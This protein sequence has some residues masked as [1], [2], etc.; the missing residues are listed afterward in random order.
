VNFLENVNINTDKTSSGFYKKPQALGLELFLLMLSGNMKL[1]V[2]GRKYIFYMYLVLFGSCTREMVSLLLEAASSALSDV[3]PMS[4]YAYSGTG[5][6]SKAVDDFISYQLRKGSIIKTVLRKRILYSLSSVGYREL[7]NFLSSPYAATYIDGRCAGWHPEDVFKAV[8]NRSVHSSTVGIVFL[9]MAER[10][11]IGVGDFALNTPIDPHGSI[12]RV[13]FDQTPNRFR[14][15]ARLLTNSPCRLEFFFENDMGTERMDAIVAKMERYFAL[16]FSAE[17]SLDSSC[18][19]FTIGDYRKNS[20]KQDIRIPGKNKLQVYKSCVGVLMSA[21][22]MSGD[23]CSSDTGRVIDL[24]NRVNDA[25]GMAGDNILPEIMEYLS[26]ARRVCPEFTDIYSYFDRTRVLTAASAGEG[27]LSKER[28]KNIRRDYL[29]RREKIFDW[30]R[31]APDIPMLVKRGLR[32]TASDNCSDGT[33]F[34]YS[35]PSLSAAGVKVYEKPVREHILS[36]SYRGKYTD[37]KDCRSGHDGTVTYSNIRF[38]QAGGTYY[39][40]ANCRVLHDEKG[41]FM[42]SLENISDDISARMRIERYFYDSAPDIP[43]LRIYIVY[44]GDAYSLEYMEFLKSEYGSVLD[45]REDI[46]L[47]EI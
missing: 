13:S 29:V 35:Y 25:S 43:F 30:C 40:F 20:I 17:R 38:F 21:V 34:I 24:L 47:L 42:Y 9:H 12:R 7:S 11:H 45:G 10:C 33:D 22:G 44:S 14:S 19:H 37:I 4:T 39:P 3:L 46:S 41:S 32:I 16:I 5:I 15:D 23:V 2:K 1:P 26:Y 27:V 28:G 31:N 18:V 6:G 36:Y 8:K